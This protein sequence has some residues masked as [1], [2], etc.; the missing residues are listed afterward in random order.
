MHCC[1]KTYHLQ[2]S[3][4]DQDS[5]GH[6]RTTPVRAERFLSILQKDGDVLPTPTLSLIH[7]GH[8]DTVLRQVSAIESSQ[9]SLGIDEGL[10]SLKGKRVPL[11]PFG[12]RYV[13]S[14]HAHALRYCHL[15]DHTA[16]RGWQSKLPKFK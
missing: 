2:F 15:M 4:C 3:R 12:C 1:R 8:Y 9:K 13:F 5:C 16:I 6:C 7:E 14:S 10:P 11:C